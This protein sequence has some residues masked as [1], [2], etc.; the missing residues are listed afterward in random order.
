MKYLHLIRYKNL[1]FIA[2]LQYLMRFAIIEPIMRVFA[3]PVATN[4]LHFSL[5]VIATIFIAAA[6]YVINDYFDT[7]IDA[8]NRPDKVIVGVSVSKEQA[9][10]MHQ[11]LTGIGVAAG[12]WVAYAAHSLTV[13]LIM[14]M[15]PG[16]LWF[17]S[18]SYKR[19]FLIGNI[20]VALTA[21]FVPLVVIQTESAFLQKEY[22]ELIL[23]TPVLPQLYGWVCGFALFAF[24]ITW[25]REVI[26]DMEDEEGD[27]E[28]E[29]RTLPIKWGM[30]Y[31]KLFLY[32]LIAI[33]L[34]LLAYARF[35]LIHF[36]NDTLTTRYLI[37]G[38]F[39]PFA[40]LVYLIV[41][42]KTP[43]DFHQAST[44][45]KF[46]MIIGV[47]YSVIFYFLQAKIFGISFLNLFLVQ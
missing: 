10:L 1:L 21:A 22:G 37:F 18:A 13:G 19:Q 33:T 30:K 8:I 31:A 17:Y 9:M 6:G 7:R 39:L 27:R 28:M 32:G 41:K 46:I 25:I 35:G 2:A 4:N 34:G 36:P 23:Q 42:A 3:I 26:K 11:I 47:L 5:L 16:L 44:F 45:T 12:L 38:L 29:S 43:E 20:I 15:I 14:V 40:Y 24:F